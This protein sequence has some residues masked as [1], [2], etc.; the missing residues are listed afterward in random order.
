MGEVGEMSEMSE[1]SEA[2]EIGPQARVGR[3]SMV[4]DFKVFE[5][6]TL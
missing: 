6:P 5:N 4:L 1:M 3:T 2:S